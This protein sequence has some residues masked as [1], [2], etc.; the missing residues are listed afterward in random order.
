LYVQWKKNGVEDGFD[1]TGKLALQGLAING[2]VYL[3]LRF[4]NSKIHFEASLDGASW[5]NTYSETFALPGYSLDTPFYY[6]PS[7]YNTALNSVLVVDD[8]SISSDTP[9]SLA[10]KPEAP[11]QITGPIPASFALQNYP[12]PFNAAT[13]IRFALPQDAE[14]HLAIFDMAGR[15]VRELATESRRAGTYEVNWDGKNRDDAL[16]STW[17]LS[18]AFAISRGSGRQMVAN[19]AAGDDGEVTQ[20][21]SLKF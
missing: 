18:R 4:D 16:L 15:E 8:F 1:V 3:R 17:L 2:A 20:K 7:A 12:N 21:S 9:S 6:E 10:A 14:I 13:N 5:I 11:E 19:C